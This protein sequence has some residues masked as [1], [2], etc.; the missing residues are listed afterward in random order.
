MTTQRTNRRNLLTAIPAIGLAGIIAAASPA[1]AAPQTPIMSLF[2]QWEAIWQDSE[3]ST[4][5]SDT[6]GQ[7]WSDGMYEIELQ[8]REIPAQNPADFIAKITVYSAYGL[9]GL[10]DNRQW[11]GLWAEADAMMG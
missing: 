1:I 2:R 11:P 5:L 7:I 6:A 3:T 4:D 10:S 8:M 9:H